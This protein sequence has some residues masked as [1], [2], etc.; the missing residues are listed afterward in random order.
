MAFAEFG[1]WQWTNNHDDE[2]ENEA[3]GA[4]K[5]FAVSGKFYKNR[6]VGCL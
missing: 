6:W 5:G 4:T 1:D 3:E 2:D